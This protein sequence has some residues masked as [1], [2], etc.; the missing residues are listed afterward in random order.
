MD[1]PIL[2][3]TEIQKKEKK[4]KTKDVWF[5]IL[6]FKAGKFFSFGRLTWH[7]VSTSQA[8]LLNVIN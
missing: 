8:L 1:F 2:V 6:I 4:G 5:W 7:N 3:W